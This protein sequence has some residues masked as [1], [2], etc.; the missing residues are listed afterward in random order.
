MKTSKLVLGTVQFGLNYGIA[1][2]YGKPPLKK[3]KRIIGIAYEHGIRILDTASAYGESESILGTALHELGL[4][5][6]MRIVSKIPHLPENTT[7][8]EAE[9]F[10]RKSLSQSL[11][12]LQVEQLEA[13]LF[14]K[15][16]DLKYL[17]LLR[18]MKTEGLV[19]GIGVS[20]DSTVP[21]GVEQADLVQVPGNVLDRRFGKFIQQ[22]HLHNTKFF[23]RSV[24]LQGLLLMPEE[25]IPESLAGIKPYRRKLEA[26]AAENSISFPELCMRYL[27]SI[28]E[29]DGILT[30]V[31]TPEQLEYNIEIAEK[32]PLS[33]ELYNAILN[34][35]PSLPE[36]WIRPALWKRKI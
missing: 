14:H 15:E 17:P 8:T 36:E 27:L 23:V 20:L 19:R 5:G 22:A 1:N 24:Y 29:I 30:G 32:G 6:S 16:N 35:V 11:A 13:V 31:D 3:V 26:L 34:A 12:N 2:T 25:K 33:S 18:K 28:P 21:S 4:S 10:I 9:E 7:K